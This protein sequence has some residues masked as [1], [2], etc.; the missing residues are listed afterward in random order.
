MRK[1]ENSLHISM[2]YVESKKHHN[3]KK[4]HHFS[5]RATVRGLL[6]LPNWPRI[7]SWLSPHP[8]PYRTVADDEFPA[9]METRFRLDDPLPTGAT[10]IHLAS[11]RNQLKFVQ[12]TG[13]PP[14]SG[15]IFDTCFSFVRFLPKQENLK[16]QGAC[17]KGDL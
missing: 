6:P 2:C 5:S 11:E 1:T 7:C 12:I 15:C 10:T 8:P 13:F 14:F 3:C 16:F 4:T 9:A 17:C